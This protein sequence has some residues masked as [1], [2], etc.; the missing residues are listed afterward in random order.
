MGLTGTI[1]H[2]G[3]GDV[4]DFLN[5]NVTSV[6]VTS[7]HRPGDTLIVTYDTNKTATYELA[8]ERPDSEFKLQPDGHTGTELILVPILG[9]AQAGVAGHLV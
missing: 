4:I 2:W 1:V 6:N 9:V 8:L 7:V 3:I 5:T